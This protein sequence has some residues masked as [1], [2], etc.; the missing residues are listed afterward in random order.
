[1]KDT[2]SSEERAIANLTSFHFDQSGQVAKVSNEF[3]NRTGKSIERSNID[4]NYLKSTV[5]NM[6]NTDT[7]ESLTK[8]VNVTSTQIVKNVEEIKSKLYKIFENPHK[9]DLRVLRETR[10][11]ERRK[12]KLDERME[13]LKP[14]RQ[15]IRKYVEKEKQKIIETTAIK[16]KLITQ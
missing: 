14:R 9:S 10:I 11:D 12:M 6:S 5:L 16:M 13:E 4:C 1:M 8:N 7:Q 3:I 15:V 2:Q